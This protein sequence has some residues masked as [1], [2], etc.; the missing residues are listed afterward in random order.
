MFSRA[1][2]LKLNEEMRNHLERNEENYK[3][4]IQILIDNLFIKDFSVWE[5]KENLI[6]IFKI[7]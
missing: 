2:K 6:G 7:P 4:L 1:F 5:G 3:N